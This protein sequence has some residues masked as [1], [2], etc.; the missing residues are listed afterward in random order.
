MHAQKAISD[1]FSFGSVDLTAPLEHTFEFQND[2]SE[3]LEI[4]NVQLTPPLTVTQM[5]ARVGPGSLGRVTVRM[6]RPREK[7]D[8]KGFVTVNFKNQNLKPLYF[9]VVG[10]FEAT[11]DFEP[12]AAFFVSTQ[13]GEAKTRSIVITSHEP[14]PL[15]ILEVK[16]DSS[17]FSTHLET[18]ESG[19]RY[20][21]TLTVKPDSPAGRETKYITLLTSS[22]KHPLL[23]VQANTA[24][25]ERVYTFPEAIN[26]KTIPVATLKGRPQLIQNLSQLLMVY[27][28]G[29]TS[30][31]ISARS[32][33]P[34]LRL[35]LQQAQLKDRYGI[36]I[37]IIPEKLTTGEV[38]GSIIVTTNDPE[39][40]QII[41]PTSAT[42]QGSW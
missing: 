28:H 33:V 23:K 7:G 21:L 35:T 30:F 10:K 26:F 27:Q 1:L 19:R 6:E 2:R 24:V 20:R 31:K 16:H 37:E 25:H 29:G 3:A 22:Q 40:P 13:R 18:L 11:I 15:N 38:Q 39:F 42:V 17:R 34:F 32:D 36:Q 12:F 14:E 4:K 8:F 9:W 5:T 41:V